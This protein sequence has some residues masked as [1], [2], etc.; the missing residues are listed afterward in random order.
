MKILITGATG[1]VGSQLIGSVQENFPKA[2]IILAMRNSPTDAQDRFERLMQHLRGFCPSHV[3]DTRRVR[4]LQW[5]EATQNCDD[6][7]DYIFH[8]AAQTDFAQTLAQARTDNLFPTL[9]LLRMARCMPRLKR[10]VHFSTAFVCGTQRGLIRE[11]CDRP[12]QFNNTYEQT[13]WESELAVIRADIPYTILR[14]S[15]I[16]GDSRSGYTKHFRVFYSMLRLWLTGAIP[17][18]P[19]L[20]THPVDIVPIDY[21]T[22]CALA[23]A[24]DE[25]C[26]KGIFHICSGNQAVTPV[27]I[28][29]TAMHAF[30][31]DLGRL[32]PYWILPLLANA[33]I[34][35]F[36]PER[37]S[38]IIKTLEHHFPYMGHAKR[39][40]STENIERIAHSNLLDAIPHFD[41]YGIRLFDYCIRTQW[42]KKPLKEADKCPLLL[43]DHAKSRKQG[44]TH[45]V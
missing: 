18:A 35:Y 24:R 36:V 8:A 23:I 43:H 38:E 40:F 33:P 45:Y 31:Q 11:T 9:D 22:R 2:D 27:H 15:I 20:G 6:D 12:K 32:S 16:V 44:D 21:V 5:N 7:F 25:R 29:S 1:F 26:E 41:Q 10:F 4:A 3:P 17:R 28:F 14:P 30:N 37:L 42:G 19:I 39:V 13:K 34:R